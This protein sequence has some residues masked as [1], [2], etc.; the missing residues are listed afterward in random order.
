VLCILLAVGL[1]FSGKQA[2]AEPVQPEGRYGFDVVISGGRVMDP[3]TGFDRVA[4][5]GIAGGRIALI[6]TYPIPGRRVI[7]AS[8]MA[9]S[10]GFID[11]CVAGRPSS[12]AD[13]RNIEAWKVSDGV[14]TV[15]FLHDGTGDLPAYRSMLEGA[16]HYAN[17][18]FSTRVW[19]YL[20]RGYTLE[21]KLELV[22]ANLDGGALGVSA[23][24][25]YTPD[26]GTEELLAYG[27][28]AR[29]YGVPL[30]LHLRYSS[31][32]RELEGVAEA[33]RIALE[34]GAH[35][36][37]FHLPSTGGTY[38]MDRALGM[39]RRARR[40][41]ARIDADL[42]AYTYWATYINAARF[43]RGW[44]QRYD[45]TYRDLFYVPTRE[46]L[47][48]ATFNRYRRSGGLIVVPENTMSLERSLLPALREELVYIAS[49]SACSVPFGGEVPSTGHPRGTNNFARA[50]HLSR[51]AGIPLM[52]T[53]GK[54]TLGPARVME[55]T[56]PTFRR[57]G[58][59]QEGCYADITVFDY[60]QVN[61]EGT[62]LNR[63]VPSR[64]IRAV[65]VGGE[66]VYLD[67]E[68]GDAGA[69]RFL[70]RQPGAP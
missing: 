22:R 64:G 29:E 63:A 67:G 66:V 18:G 3:E 59:M 60:R 36:H 7:D 41:G 32:E 46:Y 68:M 19:D 2:A 55:G 8:G 37:I 15:L 20:Y 45:L 10:P 11:L 57:R 40:L 25:E 16:G 33:V 44:Q 9:V 70:L 21:E 34:T 52:D 54:M 43:N 62:V 51:E 69:G 27:R 26:V 1:L 5:V 31:R 28:V 65:L 35:V 30:F 4:N 6:T 23:S 14:T 47:T 13:A 17:I 39:L 38:H 48:E 12:A 58:R 50:L 61:G 56:D 42:Y 53:L 49:D 24:P